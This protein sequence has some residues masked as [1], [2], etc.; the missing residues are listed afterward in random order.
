VFVLGSF[1]GWNSGSHPLKNTANGDWLTTIYLSPGRIV[2]YFDV[3]GAAWLDP[4]DDR[5]IPNG[6]GSEYSVRE[7]RQPAEAPMPVRAPRDPPAVPGVL[8][9]EFESHREK[10][11]PTVVLH[12]TGTVDLETDAPFPEPL[13]VTDQY[14]RIRDDRDYK[15]GLR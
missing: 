10:G 12:P 2:Y 7:V 13:S 9:A 5:R 6:W 4:N 3:D 1:N 11:P 15:P 8:D 14:R